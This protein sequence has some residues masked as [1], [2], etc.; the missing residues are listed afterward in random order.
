MSIKDNL[1]FAKSKAT[2][3]ELEVALKKAEANFVF[4]FPK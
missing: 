1:L 2:K 4:D 3:K